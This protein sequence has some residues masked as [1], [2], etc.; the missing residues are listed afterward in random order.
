MTDTD[1]TAEQVA[2]F[3]LVMQALNTSQNAET[4]LIESAEPMTAT[5]EVERSSD[6]RSTESVVDG[7]VEYSDE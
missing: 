7:E 6:G 1:P 5:C 3:A 4:G 2:A